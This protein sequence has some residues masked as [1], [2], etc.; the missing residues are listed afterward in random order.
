[1]DWLF[2]GEQGV[3]H[4]RV[5]G[6]LLRNDRLLAQGVRGQ[7][8]YALIGGHLQFGETLEAALIREFREETGA[9]IRCQRLL[10]TEENF[11]TWNGVKAHNL[12]FYYLIDCNDAA[13]PE[14]FTPSRDNDQV[15][16]G[17]L[18]LE[19]LPNYNLYPAF[20]KEEIFRLFE[21]PKHFI[22]RE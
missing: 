14:D 20:L 8:E 1:M 4:V 17:W 12:A 3:C 15:I 5:A 10:W 18:P 2:H 9:E 13:F 21:T 19:H 7:N 6:V 16:F 11:W 22:T